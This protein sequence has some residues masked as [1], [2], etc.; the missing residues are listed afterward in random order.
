MVNKVGK[1]APGVS[2]GH[3]AYGL[4]GVQDHRVGTGTEGASISS[5]VR[6]CSGT[7]TE[8]TSSLS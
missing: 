8:G 7:G 5:C 2:E 6:D 4:D 3:P 1:E